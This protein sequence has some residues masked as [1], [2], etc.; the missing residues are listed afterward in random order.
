MADF[1]VIKFSKA[2][3]VT[4]SGDLKVRDE[5][6]FEEH[7][8]LIDEMILEAGRKAFQK[9]LNECDD[10]DDEIAAIDDELD[11][12]ELFGDDSYENE[13]DI[14]VSDVV[15]DD[16]AEDEGESL[17]EAASDDPVFDFDDDVLLDPDWDDDDFDVENLGID[18]SD[19]RDDE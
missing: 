17:D 16:E 18:V 12:D 14:M 4:E 5:E 7:K 10:I 1:D 19:L 8:K 15:S 9:V 2:F 3:T 13:G 6:L 11:F